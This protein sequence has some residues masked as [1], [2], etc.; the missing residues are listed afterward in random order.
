MQFSGST[1]A[2]ELKTTVLPSLLTSMLA[3]VAL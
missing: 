3:L 2:V 1:S